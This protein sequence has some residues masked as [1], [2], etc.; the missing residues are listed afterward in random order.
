ME[1]NLLGFLSYV[2]QSTR[3]HSVITAAMPYFRQFLDRNWLLLLQRLGC[4][5]SWHCQELGTVSHCCADT[6][7][8]QLSLCFYWDQRNIPGGWAASQTWQTILLERF[9]EVSALTAQSRGAG[10]GHGSHPS[11]GAAVTEWGCAWL[12]CQSAQTCSLCRGFPH[13]Q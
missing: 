3:S 1:M 2:L 11:P 9:L 8:A 5:S 7:P 10:R 6:S 4:L 13:Y 12:A